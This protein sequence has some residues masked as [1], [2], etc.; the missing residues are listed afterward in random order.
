LPTLTG[1]APIAGDKG[2]DNV[3]SASINKFASDS[4]QTDFV[5]T[6]E[7][8]ITLTYGQLS[9]LI[10]QAVTNAVEKAI[11][12]LQDRVSSLEGRI[13]SLEEENAALTATQETQ[14][15]NQLIQLQL[16]NN[17]R[18]TTRK[19]TT[20]IPTGQK[21]L[22]RIAKIDEVLKA[23]GSTTLKELGKMLKIRPQEMSRLV[24]KLDKR[25]YEVFLR[26][27]DKREKVLRLR[28]QNR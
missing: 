28:A 12:P 1:E 14:A 16:I 9:D 15:D 24:A 11:Q 20:A 22:E 3:A 4:M 6:S 13:P 8:L 2:M 25:R 5:P 10:T 7:Q 21:T 27:G 26:A 18:E 19:T 17:L 23:R